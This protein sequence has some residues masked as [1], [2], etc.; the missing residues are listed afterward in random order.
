MVHGARTS[1][2]MT[3]LS[4]A[5]LLRSVPKRRDLARAGANEWRRDSLAIQDDHQPDD[6]DDVQHQ[7]GGRNGGDGTSAIR[8]GL[9]D[10]WR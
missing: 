8:E 6:C 5:L 1:L 3:T 4:H 10:K 2:G 7:P 9:A